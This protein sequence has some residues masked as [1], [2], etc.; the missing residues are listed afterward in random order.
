MS[1][2]DT[3]PRTPEEAE[4]RLIASLLADPLRLRG[5]AGDHED[6]RVSQPRPGLAAAAGTDLQ[7]FILGAVEEKLESRNGALYDLPFDQWSKEYRNWVASQTSRNLNFDDSR[8]SIY[9]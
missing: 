6:R 2:D 5:L 7:S 3:D 8:E 1:T 4:Q 9:D